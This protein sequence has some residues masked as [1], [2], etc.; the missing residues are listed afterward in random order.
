MPWTKKTEERL[1]GINQF[2]IGKVLLPLDHL[3]PRINPGFSVAFALRDQ[4]TFEGITLCLFSAI[5]CRVCHLQ[6]FSDDA[7]CSG[8]FVD[9]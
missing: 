6:E 7:N 9:I 8:L 3:Q 1:A 4:T 5:Q 2:S